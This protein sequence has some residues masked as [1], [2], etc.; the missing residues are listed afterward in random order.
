M[1]GLVYVERTLA[2]GDTTDP[3]ATPVLAIDS[4]AT[5]DW[6]RRIERWRGGLTV[7]ESTDTIDEYALGLLSCPRLSLLTSPSQA[8]SDSLAS[9]CNRR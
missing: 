4:A 9:L 8:Q 6:A 2:A 5:R 7:R 3:R 1:S